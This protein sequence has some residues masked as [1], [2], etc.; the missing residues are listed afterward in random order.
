MLHLQV[1]FQDY[2]CKLK[3]S[4]G[5]TCRVDTD[6]KDTKLKT[7]TVFLLLYLLTFLFRLVY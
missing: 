6:K 3:W 2:L 7:P 1:K 5:F 4:R